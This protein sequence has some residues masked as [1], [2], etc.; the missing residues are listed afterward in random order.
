MRY[1]GYIGFSETYEK[2]NGIWDERIV[3]FPYYGDVVRKRR[4]DSENSKINDDLTMDN[5]FSVIADSYLYSSLGRMRY[6]TYMGEKWKITRVE[7]PSRP[8]VT[9]SVGGVY[10][11]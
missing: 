8:R 9:I 4:Q 6:I 5:Q 2:D 1:S 11:G 7:Y 3:E 10:N